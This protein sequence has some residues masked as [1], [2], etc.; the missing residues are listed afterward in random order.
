MHTQKTIVLISAT[1]GLLALCAACN[2]K[3]RVAQ[4]KAVQPAKAKAKAAP[5]K[6][7]VRNTHPPDAPVIIP[8]PKLEKNTVIKES[9]IPGAGMG[10]FAARDIKKGEHIGHYGGVLL[11]KQDR[12]ADDEYA[13]VV[14]KCAKEKAKPY[15]VIDGRGSKAHMIRVNFAPYEINGKKTGL[16]NARIHG[17]CEKPYIAFAARR[18]IKKGEELFTSYGAHYGYHRFMHFKAV[19][20]HFCKAAKIDCS[21]GFTF[22]PCWD[23]KDLSYE[24]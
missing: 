12:K 22:K 5:P 21:G 19:Q 18:D 13:V 8:D 3:T 2:D 6:G 7:P 4:A 11:R 15:V 17:L 10:A 14:P 9:T 24:K 20:D 1:I 16:Q 23:C